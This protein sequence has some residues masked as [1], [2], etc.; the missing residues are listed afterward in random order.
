VELASSLVSLA[1][2]LMEDASTLVVHP[3]LLKNG[4][5]KKICRSPTAGP[6]SRPEKME[7]VVL[8]IVTMS[9]QPPHC[10]GGVSI[11]L[12]IGGSKCWTNFLLDHPSSHPQS[13]GN[14]SFFDWLDR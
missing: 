8:K 1:R 10:G 11:P 2:Y 7:E 5:M 9:S 13:S 3:D 4:G 12:P 6:S 14:A